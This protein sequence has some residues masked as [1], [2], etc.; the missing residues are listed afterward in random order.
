M[1]NKICRIQVNG[2]FGFLDHDVTLSEEGVTFIH[3][4]NGCGKTTFLKLIEAFYEWNQLV[5]ASTKF[6]VVK[7]FG[8]SK[9]SG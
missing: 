9:L 7:L 6:E 5:L 4:P 1:E 3:G 8:T 2:L